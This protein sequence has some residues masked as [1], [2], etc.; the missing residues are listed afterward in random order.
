MPLVI[1]SDVERDHADRVT[2]DQVNLFLLVIE[3]EGENTI[4]ILDEIN[5]FL[6]VS[7]EDHL[8]IGAGLELVIAF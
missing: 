7:G 8:A 1:V 3:S 4:E 6:L 5:P 2:G